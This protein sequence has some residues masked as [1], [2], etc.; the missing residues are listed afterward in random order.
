MVD[1]ILKDGQEDKTPQISVEDYNKMK[2]EL[3]A[4]KT[5]RN[6][7]NSEG[8]AMGH[9]LKVFKDEQHFVTL[10]NSD[11]K[12]TDKVVKKLNDYHGNEASAQEY[13]DTIVKRQPIEEKSYSKEDIIREIEEKQSKDKSDKKLSK[14]VK[15]A[16]IDKDSD[17]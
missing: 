17:Y 2:D 14:L 1:N 6:E 7:S 9:L 8:Q 4:V 16:G 3:D 5:A 12:M 11:K 15:E 10:F 13:Y